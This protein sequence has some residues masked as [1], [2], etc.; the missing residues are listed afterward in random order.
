MEYFHDDG[1]FCTNSFFHHSSRRPGFTSC[2]FHP[3]LECRVQQ[4]QQQKLRRKP[5]NPNLKKKRP[6]LRD[7]KVLLLK[8]YK[9]TSG[10]WWRGEE[11]QTG[12]T[13]AIS[14]TSKTCLHWKA[15]GM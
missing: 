2:H 3:R 5:E 1:C 9:N 8:S 6:Q 11:L 4:L 12:F 10:R 13:T 15:S 7:G 14:N